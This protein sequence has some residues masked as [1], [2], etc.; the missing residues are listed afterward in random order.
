LENVYSPPDVGTVFRLRSKYAEDARLEPV[1]Q[2]A[3]ML[4]RDGWITEGMKPVGYTDVFT[5]RLV[6]YSNKFPTRKHNE[7]WIDGGKQV[8]VFHPYTFLPF[9]L[10]NSGSSICKYCDSKHSVEEIIALFKKEWPSLTKEVLVT[11]LMK[12]LLL[13]EELDLIEFEG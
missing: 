8:A 11:D 9:F 2:I 12:F 1:K 5:V 4:E 3:S 7:H 10:N 13:L 6:D